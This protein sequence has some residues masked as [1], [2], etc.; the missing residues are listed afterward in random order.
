MLRIAWALRVEVAFYVCVALLLTTIRGLPFRLL[1]GTVALVLLALDVWY[2]ILKPEWN[3]LIG[4][5]PFFCAGA[6]LYFL[7][8]GS[9]ANA[10]LFALGLVL[11]VTAVWT[12]MPIGGVAVFVT[13]IA[14]CALLA[15]R[16]RKNASLDRL[17]GDLSYPVYVGHWL[18]LLAFAN[19]VGLMSPQLCLPAQILTTVVAL[20]LPVAYFALIDRAVRRLREFVRGVSIR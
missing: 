12:Q 16:V 11:A 13:L 18:P 8:S 17:L 4:S 2:Q 5:V 20:A 7:V 6:A 9:K 10:L 15:V 3:P 1:F 19:V 14:G